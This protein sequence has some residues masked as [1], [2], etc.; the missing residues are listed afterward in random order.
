MTFFKHIS[1]DQK[2]DDWYNKYIDHDLKQHL[3]N[4]IIDLRD[5]IV[6]YRSNSFFLTK[7]PQKH[8]ENI[9]QISKFDFKNS[10]EYVN[11]FIQ[12]L[13]RLAKTDHTLNKILIN[14]LNSYK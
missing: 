8:A 12:L 4:N 1:V 14:I 11:I 9:E 7:P 3:M 10:K 13:K 5:K 6:N 2:L